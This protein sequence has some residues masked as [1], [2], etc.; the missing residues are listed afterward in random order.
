VTLNN[1]FND[2]TYHDDLVVIAYHTSADPWH[3][4]D[5]DDHYNRIFQY[6]FRYIPHAFIDGVID[7]II[8]G[9]TDF[10]TAYWNRIAVESPMSIDIGIAEPTEEGLTVTAYST[11]ADQNVI[12]NYRIRFALVTKYYDGWTGANGQ[13]EWHHDMVSMLPSEEGLYFHLPANS[14]NEM[15]QTFD[16]PVV[17]NGEEQ[18]A[19]N[20]MAIVFVQDEGTLEVLQAEWVDVSEASSATEIASIPAEF[21]LEQNYPNPFNPSTEIAFSLPSRADVTLTVFDI[22][23]R[24]VAILANGQHNSGDHRVNF[25][26]SDLASGIYFYTLTANID[27][28][29]QSQT[30]KMILM[31]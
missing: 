9:V 24:E 21:V 12:G 3:N 14:A 17:L 30:R 23:G 27:G 1:F 4:L 18:S 19:D 25:D 15:S 13:S 28:Q 16:W 29:H 26:A 10:Q 22:S 2:P 11:S 20:L 31:K 7:F 6:D 8:E 5:P